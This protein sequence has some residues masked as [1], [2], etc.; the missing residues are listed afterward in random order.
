[1]TEDYFIL[2]NDVR[3]VCSWLVYSAMERLPQDPRNKSLD[4]E[5]GQVLLDR[6]ARGVAVLVLEMLVLEVEVLVL[7]TL[8]PVV[9]LLG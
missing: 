2:A 6:E 3:S 9:G 5:R 1:M 4:R 7:V 8:D